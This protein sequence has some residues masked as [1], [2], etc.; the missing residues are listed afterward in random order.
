MPV[1]KH[2][3]LADIAV[4][5]DLAHEIWKEAYSDI[6]SGEQLDYMLEMI[7]SPSSLKNQLL[8]LEHKFILVMEQDVPVG[9]ASY[10]PKE[11]NSNT[12]RLHKIYV[13]AR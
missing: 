8:T 5:S 11:K 7:Y 1:I 12:Y 10:S 3:E 4:I 13:L 6:L 9:F 2:A